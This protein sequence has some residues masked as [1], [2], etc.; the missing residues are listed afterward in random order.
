MNQTRYAV[1]FER[2][3]TGYGAYAPDLPGCVATGGTLDE[4]R[5]RMRE[6]ITFHLRSIREDGDDIPKP[7]HVEMLEVA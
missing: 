4:T 2:S 1:V 7:S 3:E 5:Q 6:A